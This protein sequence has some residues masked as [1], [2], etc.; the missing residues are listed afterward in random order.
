LGGGSSGG[1]SSTSRSLRKKEC[2]KKFFITDG[3]EDTHFATLGVTI[4]PLRIRCRKRGWDRT[5]N[6]IVYV[7][8][9]R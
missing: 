9:K 7:K 1:E 6:E 3:K 4:T 5:Y 2:C 8:G